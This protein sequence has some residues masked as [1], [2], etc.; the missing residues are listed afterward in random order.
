MKALSYTN[1]RKNFADTMNKIAEDHEPVLITRKNSE[2]VIMLSLEDYESLNETAYLLK[3]PKNALRLLE[4]IKQIEDGKTL[5][6]N[7]DL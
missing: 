3:S 2:S 1:V 6:K 7:L 5:R 4:S